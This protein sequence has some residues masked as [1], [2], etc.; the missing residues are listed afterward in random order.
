MTNSRGCGYGLGDAIGAFLGD[1]GQSVGWP[2]CQRAKDRNLGGQN[3]SQTLGEG[4]EWG[5]EEG[6][7]KK[8]AQKFSPPLV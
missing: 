5:G 8:G 1:I 7:G 3:Q 4:L 6:E 2:V